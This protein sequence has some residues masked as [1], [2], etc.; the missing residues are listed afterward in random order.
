MSGNASR[1][2]GR[3]RE[4]AYIDHLTRIGWEA[5]RIDGAGDIVAGKDGITLLLQVKSTITPYAHFGRLDRARLRE[6][7][8]RA[9]WI[10]ALVWWPKGRGLGGV[11][12]L[13]EWDWPDAKGPSLNGAVDIQLAA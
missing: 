7:A 8:D 1:R 11:K 5:Y 2:R 10:A 3:Q 13:F 12:V 9:G 6:A 4:L